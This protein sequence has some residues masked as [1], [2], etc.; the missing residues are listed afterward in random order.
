MFKQPLVNLL[1]VSQPEL[2]PLSP[3]Y[4]GCQLQLPPALQRDRCRVNNELDMPDSQAAFLAT[5]AL[6][7]HV[8]AR[9]PGLCAECLL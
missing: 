8:G 4:C 5:P 7:A 9:L 2:P 6:F 1:Q 3:G